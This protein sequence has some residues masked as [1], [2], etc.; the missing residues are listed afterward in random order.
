MHRILLYHRLLTTILFAFAIEA[1]AQQATVDSLKTLVNVARPDTTKVKLYSELSQELSRQDIEQ[2]L[3]YADLGLDLAR[4]LSYNYGVAL[5]LFDK[6]QAVSR[7]GQ[8]LESL[9]L[10][11]ESLIYFDG[12]Y[13]KKDIALVYSSI[14]S[15]HERLGNL[16]EALENAQESYRLA[17]EI[18]DDASLASAS[19]TIGRIYGRLGNTGKALDYYK[20]N[21]EINE[22][23]GN[24]RGKGSALNNIGSTYKDLGEYEKAITSLQE[25]MV[26]N[27]KIN[28]L[29]TIIYNYATLSEVY[30]LIGNLDSAE[31]YA[32]QSLDLS[33]QVDDPF[34]IAYG[35]NDMGR[36]LLGRKKYDEAT[37]YLNKA[38]AQSK[39]IMASEVVELV[40]QNLNKL[41]S[42]TGQFDSA[43]Y[44]LSEYLQIKEDLLFKD[45][46]RIS[47]LQIYFM[48]EQKQSQIDLLN[49]ENELKEARLKSRNALTLFSAIGGVIGI[50]L[51]IWLFIINRKRRE[52]NKALK[53]QKKDLELTSK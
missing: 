20:K 26:V 3:Q 39:T 11:R 43:Y 19:G 27:K 6:A 8:F 40:V 34:E 44:Y 38:Y 17:E 33:V 50:A 36:V 9:K 15:N 37:V 30:Q 21:L 51:L 16:S 31:Y 52:Q 1:H 10:L 18:S 22:K 13:H 35:L 24:E 42:Q 41:Y 45:S 32:Q 12:K 29:L 7:K 47:D 28:N 46:K 2:S 23:I 14:S 48:N 5:L 25:S 53:I 4:Q 49:R